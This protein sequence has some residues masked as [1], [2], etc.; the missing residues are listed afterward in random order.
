MT[1]ISVTQV[2]QAVTGAA[3]PSKALWGAYRKPLSESQQQV[4]PRSPFYCAQATLFSHFVSSSSR[5]NAEEVQNQGSFPTE[6][7]FHVVADETLD[8]VQASVDALEDVVEDYEA[9]L[10][11]I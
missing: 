10:S 9:N 5:T 1:S 2:S 4:C 8:E 6:R 3:R 7:D 11:V